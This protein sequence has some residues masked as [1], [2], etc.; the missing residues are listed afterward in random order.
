MRMME[1]E[2]SVVTSL[3]ELRKL[4]HERITR[5]TQSRPVSSAASTARAM[6]LAEDPVSDQMTPPPVQPLSVVSAPHP[7]QQAFGQGFAGQATA[8]PAFAQPAMGYDHMPVQAPPIIQTKTS[9]KAAVAIAVVLVGAGAAGYMKLQTETQATLAAKEVAVKQAEEA[10]NKA[11]ETAAKADQQARSSL[12]Q[13]EDKLKASMAAVA[14]AAPAVA[15]TA[16][17]AA[18]KPEKPAPAAKVAHSSGRKA[19]KPA[20]HV[21]AAQPAAPR[22]SKADKGSKSDDIPNIAKKKKL[23]NDPL[24]GL[25]KL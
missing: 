8:H 10:R 12:R 9:Y 14:P 21:A 16:P 18:E 25:G 11:V 6:A 3:N 17:A 15:P 13:C 2:D 24:A 22:A 7:Q 5:Q 4:K 23:D 19:A 20:R 1:N